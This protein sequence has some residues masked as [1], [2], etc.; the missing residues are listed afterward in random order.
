MRRGDYFVTE[1]SCIKL[2][3][4]IIAIIVVPIVVTLLMPMFVNMFVVA[5]LINSIDQSISRNDRTGSKNASNFSEVDLAFFGGEEKALNA[6]KRLRAISANPID[7]PFKTTTLSVGIVSLTSNRTITEPTLFGWGKPTVRPQPVR[8]DLEH[9]G[10][11]AV[12]LIT[13][14]PVLLSPINVKPDQRAKIAV[15]GAAVFDIENAPQG[16]LAGFRIGA[17]GAERATQPH[18]TRITNNI[19][20]TERFCISMVE[21]ARL[22]RVDRDNIRIWRFTDPDLIAL[23]G[24][25]LASTGGT[26]GRLDH[27]S[28]YCR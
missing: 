14:R 25:N 5:K 20:N 1:R 11:G 4:I 13:N 23:Q 7:G 21:W 18:D 9:A 16:L 19:A 27:I 2:L 22:F 15:E 10:G 28:D 12:V 26:T 8:I 3:H 24:K 6:R 17:F